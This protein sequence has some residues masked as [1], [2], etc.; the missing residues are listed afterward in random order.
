MQR[1][2]GNICRELTG[3][4]IDITTLVDN[5]STI[6]IAKSLD[7]KRGKHFDVRYHATKEYFAEKE[8]ALK[9][10]ESK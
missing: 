2:L 9:Y 8:N 4:E 6:K 3:L 1:F 10:V 5:Q 7:T